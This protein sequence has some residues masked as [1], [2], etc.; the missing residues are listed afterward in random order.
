MNGVHAYRTKEVIA[1]EKTLGKDVTKYSNVVE[2]IGVWYMKEP[3][4]RSQ[5]TLLRKMVSSDGTSWHFQQKKSEK[6]VS[7]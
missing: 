6:Y 1:H 3:K 2:E 5:S 7:I 4:S